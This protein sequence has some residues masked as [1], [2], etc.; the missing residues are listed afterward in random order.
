MGATREASPNR[1]RGFGKLEGDPQ[2]L[3][4]VPLPWHIRIQH[5]IFFGSAV[6]RRR[7][8]IQHL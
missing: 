1:T 4:A 6:F 8:W 3:D 7:Q 2:E 5:N